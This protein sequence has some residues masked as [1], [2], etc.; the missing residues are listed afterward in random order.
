M[1]LIRSQPTTSSL[2]LSSVLKSIAFSDAGFSMMSLSAKTG[3]GL[4]ELKEKI[5]S[6]ALG[7]AGRGFGL[8]EGL[9]VTARQLDDIR[10]C[11]CSVEE[12]LSANRDGMGQ[13]I[14]AGALGRAR[15]ALERVLGISCDDALLDSVFS[16]FCVGK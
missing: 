2:S 14:V 9:N 1:P 5:V 11:L 6:L 8:N 3:E 16:R 12:A 4:D 10:A 13:D 7:G 15:L